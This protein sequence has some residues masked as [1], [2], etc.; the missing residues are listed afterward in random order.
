M[1][2][3]IKYLSDIIPLEQKDGSDW[4]D[5]RSSIDV[6]LKQGEFRLIPLG[7]ALELPRGYEA[8]VIPRSSTFKNFGVIQT[9]SFGLIDEKYSGNNDQWFMPVIAMRDTK[10]YKND[11]ICQF[12]ISEKQPKLEFEIVDDLGNK[13]RNG[14]GSTGIK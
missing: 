4:I 14:F 13:D 12:R 5:L 9:N 11:R 7:F 1:K 3:K 10:I 2:L 8:H 6:E